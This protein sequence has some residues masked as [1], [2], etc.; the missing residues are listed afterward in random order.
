MGATI[1]ISIVGPVHSHPSP[2]LQNHQLVLLDQASTPIIHIRSFSNP[3]PGL[4]VTV[5]TLVPMV[6]FYPASNLVAT[7]GM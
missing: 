4:G 2:L 6:H 1:D 7:K 3:L 5:T